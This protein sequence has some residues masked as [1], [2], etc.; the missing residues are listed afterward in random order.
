MRRRE[1]SKRVAVG[2]PGPDAQRVIERRDED[3]AVADLAGARIGGDD[4]DRLLREIGR[5][6]DLDAQFGQE[7]HDIF[8][9]AVDLGVTLLAAIA[10]DL[11]HRHPMHADRGEG[12]AHLVKFE[13]FDDRDDELHGRAVPYLVADWVDSRSEAANS[14]IFL[15]KWHKEFAARLGILGRRLPS[16][17]YRPTRGPPQWFRRVAKASYGETRCRNDPGSLRPKASSKAPTRTRSFAASSRAAWCRRRRWSGPRAC[18]A[19]KKP[20]TFRA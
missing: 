7:I 8:G 16:G 6:G 15:G 3:L 4:V 14:D 12:L 13:R 17:L 2:F 20:V 10:L 9:A 19:G 1:R 5:H 18:P 11:R